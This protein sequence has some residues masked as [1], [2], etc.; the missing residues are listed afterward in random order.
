MKTPFP[1]KLW[2]VFFFSA[3][4][5]LAVNIDC[6]SHCIPLNQE[7]ESIKLKPTPLKD[8]LCAKSI[9]L[10]WKTKAALRL[11]ALSPSPSHTHTHTLHIFH[12]H[13]HQCPAVIWGMWCAISLWRHCHRTAYFTSPPDAGSLCLWQGFSIQDKEQSCPSTA[14]CLTDSLIRNKTTEASNTKETYI[15]TSEKCRDGENNVKCEIPN[16]VGSSSGRSNPDCGEV[17]FDSSVLFVTVFEWY[18]ISQVS[19]LIAV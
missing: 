1:W 7:R 17:W 11:L 13:I 3:L 4:L 10:I 2:L 5:A 16:S 18:H 6:N 15:V 19:L 14:A 8:F 12:Q 9:S